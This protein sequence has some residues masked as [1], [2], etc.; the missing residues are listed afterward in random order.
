MP[1]R[2][3][4]MTDPETGDL[5]HE[6]VMQ[7]VNTTFPLGL[8]PEE[9]KLDTRSDDDNIDFLVDKIRQAYELKTAHEDPDHL[10]NLE[11]YVILRA[12]D[13]LWQDHLYTMDGIREAIGLR[14]HA[15]KDPLVE[16]KTEAYQVFLELMDNI[17][18]E[19]LAGLFRTTSN[20]DEY[21]NFLRKLPAKLSRGHRRARR[22]RWTG[23]RSPASPHPAPGQP[24]DNQPK[25]NIPQRREVPKVG[26][27]E[28]CPCGSGKKFKACHGKPGSAAIG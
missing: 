4:E 21:A 25:I 3:S 11:R 10:E 12:I 24:A 17:K 6:E 13:N 15:Q 16:Y 14:Q 8:Q 22:S 19:T 2:L 26:R 18:G 5:N 20:P 9:A 7:W 28:P 27:N 1:A 23:R